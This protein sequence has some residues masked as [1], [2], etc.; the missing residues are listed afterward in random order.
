M[1]IGRYIYIYNFFPLLVFSL[2]Q[3]GWEEAGEE[4]KKDFVNKIYRQID[5]QIDRKKDVQIERQIETERDREDSL[6][7]IE[8]PG[9]VSAGDAD[10]RVGGEHRV[11]HRQD[12]RV[13]LAH[14]GHLHSDAIEHKHEAQLSNSSQNLP[15]ECILDRGTL[16]F[17]L[18][19]QPELCY[20]GR[21]NPI[22]ALN[23]NN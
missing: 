19:L 6:L 9:A 15:T 18:T 13:S 5:R 2:S 3:A 11:V 10:A 20:P 17:I 23:P 22:R 16:N 21:A 12:G 4:G 1:Q 8:C 7:N 14:P